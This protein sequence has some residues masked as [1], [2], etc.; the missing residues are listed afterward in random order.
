MASLP[1]DVARHI[2]DLQGF[3][4]DVMRVS[5]LMCEE[6]G[7]D[8]D[9]IVRVPYGVTYTPYEQ[10]I[11]LNKSIPPEKEIAVRQWEVYRPFAAQLIAGTRAFHKYTLSEC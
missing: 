3:H 2:E 6:M 9:K 7:L 8:P 5:I 4:A 10:S 11:G 1:G